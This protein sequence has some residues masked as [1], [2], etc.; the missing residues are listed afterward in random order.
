MKISRTGLLCL[1]LLWVST[2]TGAPVSQDPAGAAL[3][4]QPAQ[5]PP[6]PVPAEQQPTPPQQPTQPQQQ[7]PAEENAPQ[8]ESRRLKL[9]PQPPK[10][11]DVRQPGEAGWF[12]GLF[13][14]LP[15]GTFWVDKGHEAAFTAPSR[16]ELAGGTKASPGGE[17]GVA[18]GLH[19]SLRFT[20][21]N[22]KRSGSTIAPNDLVLFAQ[23]YAKGDVL[24]TNAKLSDYKLSYEYLTWPY[25]VGARNFRLKTL[26]QVQYVTM[27]TT[28]DAPIR[29]STPDSAGNYISYAALG[30]KSYITPSFGLGV[31]EYVKRNLHLEANISAFMWPHSFYIVDADASI[32]YRI[33]H[34]DLRGGAKYFKFRTSPN[35]DYFFAGNPVGFFVG[36]RWHS[37]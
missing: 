30:S 27:R 18:A 22:T 36:L 26:W 4:Q 13:G 10:V 21:F 19:N 29:S 37:D 25:P 33:S 24:T 9:P 17:F 5:Q 31:H 35:S 32:G 16:L 11:V 8:P 12:I 6:V 7:P 15:A 34:V 23:S 14:W 20:Y 1:G 3:E 28:F 2:L